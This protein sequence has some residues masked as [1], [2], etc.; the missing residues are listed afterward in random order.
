MALYKRKINYVE[1]AKYR[2]ACLRLDDLISK[3]ED[4]ELKEFKKLY[5]PLAEIIYT[6]YEKYLSK[7]DRIPRK[8]KKAIKKIIIKR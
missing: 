3:A 2:K 5:N 6:Y 8:T 7:K 4:Y 1:Y